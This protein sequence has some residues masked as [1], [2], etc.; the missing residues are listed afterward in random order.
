MNTKDLT[1]ALHDIEFLRDIDPA[2]LGQLANIAQVCDFDAH[3]VVFREGEVAESAYLVVS[4][5]VALQVCARNMDQP[6]HIVDVGPGE[7]LGWATLTWHPRFAATAI[8][9]TPTHMIRIDGRQ[10]KS[11]CE[12]DPKFG[13]EFMRRTM[14]ALAKRL[15]AT[16]TQLAEVR[17]AHY[18]PI[19]AGA[20]AENE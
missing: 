18:A 1:H 17:L 8:A 5:R 4:G 9:L 16:W 13:Y 7:L 15:R 12:S 3:D 14:L 6:K 10:L 11:I 20:A 19:S 2:H